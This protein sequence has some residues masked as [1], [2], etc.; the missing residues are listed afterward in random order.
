MTVFKLSVDIEEDL[1]F[2]LNKDK[3]ENVI[4]FLDKLSLEDI[5]RKEFRALTFS[6]NLAVELFINNITL[7][8]E[9]MEE[10][11][12][13]C[14]L[15]MSEYKEDYEGM[16]IEEMKEDVKNWFNDWY[17]NGERKVQY[18]YDLEKK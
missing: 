5:K 4:R 7:Q 10:E 6:V 11:D 1:I 2:A 9:E 17:Y 8:I 16:T 13:F 18:W 14:E 15:N 12:V 3:K